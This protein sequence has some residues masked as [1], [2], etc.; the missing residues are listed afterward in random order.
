MASNTT[1]PTIYK[2]NTDIQVLQEKKVLSFP[3]YL[4][5]T[6]ADEFQND[7]AYMIFKI[8]TA[9]TGSKLKDDTAT[10]PVVFVEGTQ[11]SST[12]GPGA[13]LAFGDPTA[14]IASDSNRQFVDRD[15]LALQTGGGYENEKW[16][17]KPGMSRLDR[18]VVLPM[19][20]DYRVGTTLNYAD[21]NQDM[22]GNIGDAVGSLQNGTGA[23]DLMK[24]GISGLSSTLINALSAVAGAGEV[25]SAN[26]MARRMRAALNP[27][28]ET[29]FEDMDFRK[30]SFQYT[31]AP[32]S[33]HESKIVQEIIQTFRYYALPELSESKL[34]YSFPSEFEIMLMQGARENPSIPRIATCILK[35]VDVTYS[36]GGT[37]SNFKDGMA[38]Q[39]HL[40]L[41]FQELEL[42]DRNRVWSKTSKITSGY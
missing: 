17:R 1:E 25:T 42:I 4:G 32:R 7:F 20:S 22:L 12:T 19:P 3:E 35:S 14:S 13:G 34:F 6:P 21:T 27:K 39:A 29:L 40:S 31:L 24:M 36:P 37:W 2:K 28:K 41:E 16:V 18:V 8:N 15:I 26:K 5:N 30:F 23:S 9:T 38:V 11:Q 10:A 33:A